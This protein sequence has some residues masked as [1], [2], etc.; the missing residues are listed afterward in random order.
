MFAFIAAIAQAGGI[1]VDKI[2]LTRRRMEIHVFIPLLFLFLF[3]LTGLLMPHLGKISYEIIKPYYLVIFLLMIGA[4]IIWNVF[5]YQGVQQEKVHEFEMIIMFQ[6]LLTILFAAILIEKNT[7]IHLLIAAIIASL[8][9]IISHIRKN[10]FELSSGSRGLILAVIF[11]SFE[12]IL[13]KII[14]VVF[15][16]VALYFVRTG[17]IFL[18]FLILYR[19]RLGQVS[20]VNT[21]LLLATSGLGVAQMVSKLYGFQS[22]GVIYTSLILIL[23]PVLVYISSTIL[24]HERL[25]VRT[26]LSALVIIGCIVYATIFG[27]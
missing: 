17:I 13:Q 6:P 18:I 24:L 25:K 9:L 14:L 2:V 1:I 19:P 15:S 4:A 3:I 16:P 26:V 20:S 23:S 8:A 21:F 27:K 22:Y 12:I 7:N 11:M 5:Y 10:H